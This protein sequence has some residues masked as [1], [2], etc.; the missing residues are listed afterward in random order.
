MAAAFHG[1]SKALEIL[2]AQPRID[3]DRAS[4]R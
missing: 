4:A 2:L 3:I 1:Q